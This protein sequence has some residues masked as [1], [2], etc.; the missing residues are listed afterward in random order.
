MC[1]RRVP[2]V[3]G[4]GR[5]VALVVVLLLGGCYGASED[6]TAVQPSLG[7]DSRHGV[8][9]IQRFGCGLCHTIPG[10]AGAEGVVAAPLDRLGRRVYIA[11]VLRNTPENL[12]IWLQT[13]QRILP[14]NAMPDMG[15]N[16]RQARDI[17]A[18]LYTLR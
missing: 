10:V 14:G 11:G 1:L 17:A 12:M 16:E 9:L 4:S 18:Y 13:P 7:G 15:L 5:A 6:E 3:L 8:E 2:V